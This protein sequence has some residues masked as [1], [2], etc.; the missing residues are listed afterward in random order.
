MY[1]HTPNQYTHIAVH[2]QYTDVIAWALSLLAQQ[3]G[4]D[5]ILSGSVYCI[6][7]THP[8]RHFKT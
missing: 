1:I 2:Y 4:I 7:V 8:R 3:R 6:A 5:G